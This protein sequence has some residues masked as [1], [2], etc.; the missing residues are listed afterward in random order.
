MVRQAHHDV[1]EIIWRPSKEHLENSNIAR[2]MKK[3]G[4]RDYDSLIKKCSADIGWFWDECL[5]DLGV[6]WFQP[7]TK[8]V[9]GDLPWAKWFVDGKINIVQNC[10]DRHQN[11]PA[12][13]NKVAFIWEGDCGAIKKVT[14]AEL[15]DQVNRLA[16][17]MKKLGV[18][19]GDCVG[20]YMPMMPEMI[21]AFFAILK[22]GA[23]VIPIFSGFGPE[24]AAIRLAD[25]GAKLLFT[26]DYGLRRGKKIEIKKQADEALKSVPSVKK[27]IVAKRL[28][29]PVPWVEG[30]DVWFDELAPPSPSPSPTRGEGI[31]VE[32][33]PPLMGGGA[34]EGD[35]ITEILDAEERS[36]IIYTSG[37]TGKPKGTVHTHA[38]ALAQMA[39]EVTY[40]MDCKSD[41]VFFWLTD[42]GW[43]MGPWEFIGATFNGATFVIFEGAPDYPRPDRLWEMIERH[44]ISIL[45]ISPT[46]I[47]MLK[48]SGV[49]PVKK[50]DLSS[51]RILGSTGEPWDPE[52]YLWFFENIGRKKCPIINISGGTEIVGCHLSPLPICDLKP[53][54]LRGPGLGMDVDVFNEEGKSVREEVGYLV[55]KKPAPS[56]TKGFLNDPQRYLDTYFSKW[57]TIWNH[58]DWA[59]VDEDGFWFLR[60]RADDVIK[61]AGHRTGPAEIESALM[62]NPAVAECAAIGVPHEIKGESI[63]C[64]A[65]IKDGFTADERLKKEL[66]A[67][68]GAK[69]GKTLTPEE[70]KFV[71][72]LPKTRSAKIVRGAIKKKYLGLPVGDLSSIE[73]PDALDRLGE[74]S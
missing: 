19:R 12:V 46:A 59:Y 42:I 1:S 43:M 14:Y 25:A 27:V 10:L 52:S 64:F 57:P 60:G 68:V 3:Q 33:P 21:V 45:G 26:A 6:E 15:S 47:R 7:Y 54:T 2:F 67:A 32:P 63:I 13:Q 61:V 28:S 23:V 62:D 30:R 51:L 49:D 73:N 56:M 40:Y 34:G 70:I 41:D 35:P 71:K 29:E 8:T 58:G 24:P 31:S 37:T 22:I 20:I 55:C 65:V 72:A 74:S 17:G 36:I 50:H 66:K 9:E 39:K 5:K 53:C 18:G 44:K 4:I 48:K 38:G 11:N 69:L 16:D